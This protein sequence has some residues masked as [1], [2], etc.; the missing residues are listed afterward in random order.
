M[1]PVA[2]GPGAATGKREN[3]GNV[4][5]QAADLS[6]DVRDDGD[7]EVPSGQ[8][9]RPPN[10]RV[11][12]DGA[13]PGLVESFVCPT[14]GCDMTGAKSSEPGAVEADSQGVRCP[15]GAETSGGIMLEEHI[16]ETENS[17]LKPLRNPKMPT[18]KEIEEHEISH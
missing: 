3:P 9:A 6:K 11:R 18:Q 10:P 8:T 1:A 5:M 14:S 7:E 12:R 13:A 17:P 16:E 15:P 2:V 4:D